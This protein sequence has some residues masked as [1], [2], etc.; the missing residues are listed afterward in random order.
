MAMEECIIFG[1]QQVFNASYDLNRWL[2]DVWGENMATYLTWDVISSGPLISWGG[3]Q[4]HRFGISGRSVQA[5]KFHPSSMTDGRTVLSLEFQMSLTARKVSQCFY[6]TYTVCCSHCLWN[7]CRKFLAGL[8]I[9][10]LSAV[11]RGFGR[12]HIDMLRSM[13]HSTTTFLH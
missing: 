3:S 13:V 2:C 12:T 6:P 1:W 11:V 5:D 4:V 9:V 10:C 8:Q 7:M